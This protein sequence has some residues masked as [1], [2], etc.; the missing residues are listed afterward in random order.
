VINILTGIDTVIAAGVSDT[1]FP[2]WSADSQQ[3][4]YS[5]GMHI[6]TADVQTHKSFQIKIQGP[7]SAFVWSLT[8]SQ[9]IVVAVGDG[10]PGTYLVDTQHNTWI[11]LDKANVLGPIQ[12]TQIP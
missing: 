5:T 11:Q 9:Q 4:V 3:L 1:P 7:A 10:Q 6:F 12:W 8:T 2:A